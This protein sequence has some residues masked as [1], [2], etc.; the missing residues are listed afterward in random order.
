MLLLLPGLL[1][2]A[3]VWAP[4]LP[5]IERRAECSV[6]AYANETSLPAMAERMLANAPS[7]FALAGHSMGGRVALEVLR[8]A[9]ERVSRLALLDTGFRPRPAGV[10]GGDEKALRYG[11]LALARAKG[12]RA[13]AREWV[14]PMVHPDR[15]DDAA[16]IDAVLDM[17]ER[18]TADEFAGQIEALLARPDATALL[19]S[20]ACPTLVLCGRDDGW[21]KLAQHEEMA[22]L[23]PGATLAVID[24]CGHMAPMERP[25]DVGTA[26][27]HW[28]AEPAQGSASDSR[29][30]PLPRA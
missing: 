23:I 17:F 8:R 16:L 10:A 4:V 5:F 6:A 3:A 14:R 22:A 30:L 7:T 2:D 1:C 15:R 12:M 26:L 29:M 18:R 21:S 25:R 11:V 9:P 13:M 28:L 27:A 24:R 20:I 19:R